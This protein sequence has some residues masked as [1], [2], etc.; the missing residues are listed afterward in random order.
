MVSTLIWVVV[1]AGI[2]MLALWAVRELGVPEPINRVARVVVIVV[3]ILVIIGLVAGLFGVD[4]GMP[5]I[6]Q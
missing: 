1:V 2:A 4:V 3:A 5:R 6:T